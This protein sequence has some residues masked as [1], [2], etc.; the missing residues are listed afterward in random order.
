M[1]VVAATRAKKSKNNRS[2]LIVDGWAVRIHCI[3]RERPFFR[4]N[5]LRFDMHANFFLEA[6][7]Q[8]TAVP[9]RVHGHLRQ[10]FPSGSRLQSRPQREHPAAVCTRC[11]AFSFSASAINQPCVRTRAG[12]SCPGKFASTLSTEAWQKCPTC[13][14]TGWQSHMVCSHCQSLGWLFAH[15]H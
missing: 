2:L 7:K 10:R 13:E 1:A 4:P 8:K 14:A 3:E 5:S 11:A 12:N 6:L 15:K 9:Q